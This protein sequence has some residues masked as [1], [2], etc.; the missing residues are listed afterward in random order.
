M[1]VVAQ[2]SIKV[3]GF[4]VHKRSFQSGLEVYM[5]VIIYSEVIITELFHHKDLFEPVASFA[6]EVG[7]TLQGEKRPGTNCIAIIIKKFGHDYTI[8]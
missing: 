5:F 1:L 8:T 6:L 7:W 3:L 4:K 2:W